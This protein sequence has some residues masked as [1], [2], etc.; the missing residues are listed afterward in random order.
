MNLNK[1]ILAGN[2]TRSPEL[3]YTPNGTAVANFGMATNRAW[4]DEGGQRQE[5]VEYHSIVVFGRRAEIAA[6]YLTRGSLALLEGRLQTKSWEQDGIKRYRTEIIAERVQF[7]PKRQ[8]ETP[9]RE[10]IL[11]ATPATRLPHQ[12]RLTLRTTFRSRRSCRLR[13]TRK[14]DASN[15][16]HLFRRTGERLGFWLSD[17]VV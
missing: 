3:R 14:P 6:E 7:G 16:E 15:E 13:G 8:D 4:T 12:L 9:L 17:S 1:V 10:T 2:L 11:I 5:E